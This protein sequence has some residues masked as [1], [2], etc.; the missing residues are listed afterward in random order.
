M[1]IPAILKKSDPRLLRVA[2]HVGQFD[3]PELRGLVTDL[4]D[5]MTAAGGAGD[6]QAV[7]VQPACRGSTAP[8]YP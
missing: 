7:T 6:E 5:T 8:P 1:T 2:Q 3:T 4:F